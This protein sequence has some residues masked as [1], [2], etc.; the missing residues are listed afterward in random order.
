MAENAPGRAL[1][2]FALLVSGATFVLLLVGG[3]VH[4]T[5]SSLACPDWPLCYGQVFPRMEGGILFEHLHRLV[6]TSVGLMTLGLAIALQR[7]PSPRLRW[8]GLGALGLVIFQGVLG[9][10][11][12]LLR[13]PLLVSVAHL[14]TSLAFF[15]LTLAL[16]YRTLPSAGSDTFHLAA[17]PIPEQ[18]RRLIGWTALAVYAQMILGAFVRHTGS[19]LACDANPLFCRGML[20]PAGGPGERQMLH[21]YAALA[22]TGLVIAATVRLLPELRSPGRG[23]ARALA[24]ACHA[25]ILVQLGLG[26]ASVMSY[27]NPAVVTAHLGVGALLLGDLWLLFLMTGP[28]PVGLPVKI[29]V[30]EGAPGFAGPG[31]IGPGVEAPGG[32]GLA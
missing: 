23:R 1:H 10:L 6:A 26:A 22:I 5:G 32:R 3:L 17:Q 15:A 13:L 2:Q 9:G 18:S 16:A 19:G 30:P 12:V 28:E 8:M 11:T 29:P 20:W 24:I 4:A 21:R 27:L 25:L 31:F 14:A 7:Q